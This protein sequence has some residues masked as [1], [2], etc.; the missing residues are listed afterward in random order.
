MVTE[1]CNKAQIQDTITTHRLKPSMIYSTI[2]S[3]F[4]GAVL[5]EMKLNSTLN[6]FIS[7]AFSFN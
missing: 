3:Y 5:V 7:F 6:R 1:R 2:L 4:T